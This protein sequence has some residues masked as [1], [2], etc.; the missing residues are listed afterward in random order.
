AFYGRE[1]RRRVPLPT[2]PFHRE[3]YWLDPQPPH[4]DR[5]GGT[6]QVPPA[7]RAR[8]GAARRRDDVAEWFYSPSW[9]RAA[10][11]SGGVP[12]FARHW[13]VFADALGVGE[14][15]ARRLRTGGADVTVVKPSDAWHRAAPD[16]FAIDPA[17]GGD[18]DRLLDT[19]RNGPGGLPTRIIHGW[20]VTAM[21]EAEPADEET[22]LRLGF[23]SLVH[24]AKALARHVDAES[25]RIW[26]FS[27]G[28]HNVTGSER[29]SPAK[30]PLLGPSRVLPRE[31]AR[32][33][34]RSV[35]LD[36]LAPPGARELDRLMTELASEPV[37]GTE[38]VAHRGIH[39][40]AQHYVPLRLPERDGPSALRPGGVYL[41]T[42]GTGGL[43]LALAEHIVAAG[44]HVTLTARTRFPPEAEWEAFLARASAG[45]PVVEAV[46]R[47]SRLR[48]TGGRIMVLQADV[49]DPAAMRAAVERTN[50]RWG[51]VHGAF[52]A[53]GVAGGGL[54]ELKDM[55]IAAAVMRPKVRGTLVLEE[56]LAGQDLDF[57]VLF[58]SNGANIGSAGQVD[59]CAANCF[60]DAFAQDRARRQRVISID[61]GAWRGIGMAV[62]TALPPGL[63]ESRR[64][65]VEERG[66][67]AAEGLRA[68]EMILM[69][70][71]E[72]QII[73]SPTALPE[74]FAEAFSV[75]GATAPER[76]S[77]PRTSATAAHARPDIPTEYVP[78]R[79]ATEHVICEAWQETLGFERVGI[80]DSFFDLGGDSLIAVQLMGAIHARLDVRLTLGDL[81]EGLTAAHLAEL[82][83][84][85][86]RKVADAVVPE[87]AG[88][89]GEHMQR[90][91]RHQQLQRR[92]RA[93]GQ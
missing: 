15:L 36:C 90:R 2:Y 74:L 62:G 10:L 29:L 91:R 34:C 48:S 7:A 46:R 5:P 80:Q 55:N 67:S 58:G 22:G 78:P 14:E 53:A 13:L 76:S 60:L 72:P 25:R 64:R 47:L 6:S 30:A 21:T 26:V 81:Y 86:A 59:Y 50:R 85:R 35:D 8:G 11:P 56:V 4:T 84:G 66:M 51:P 33:G 45:S 28:L 38:T 79:T 27:N 69:D 77:P 61:W 93:R 43:G 24:M 92:R 3:R 9:Q 68:L 39:R 19:L 89:R 37:S 57:M 42:G 65:D 87:G 31:M 12:D 16:L 63:D 20:S 18:Y 44:G 88:E 73:V 49:S 75:D 52:H 32:T 70:A 1:R 83:E 17:R 82:A 40:W 41:I 23:G 71:A 54:I